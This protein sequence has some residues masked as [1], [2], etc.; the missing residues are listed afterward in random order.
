MF[1]YTQLYIA[2]HDRNII[3]S[4]WTTARERQRHTERQRHAERDRDRGIETHRERERERESSVVAD[5]LT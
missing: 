1:T 3:Q 5:D 2:S 4:Q